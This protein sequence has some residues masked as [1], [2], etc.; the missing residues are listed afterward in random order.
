MGARAFTMIGVGLAGSRKIRA[1]KTDTARWAYVCAHVSKLSRFVGMFELPKAIFAHDVGVCIEDL[2]D[3]IED[4]QRV[5]LIEYDDD[6]EFIRIVAWHRKVN[7]IANASAARSIAIDFVSGLLPDG[8]MRIRAVAEFAVGALE[9]AKQWKPESAD[10]PKLYDELKE[11]LAGDYQDYGE[12][13]LRCLVA[14]TK[15]ASRAIQRELGVVFP[16]YLE[17]R[18]RHR[19]DTVSTQVEV[20]QTETILKRD[21]HET[22]TQTKTKKT[23]SRE[24]SASGGP[25]AGNVMPMLRN[26]DGGPTSEL[27]SSPLASGNGGEADSSGRA[28]R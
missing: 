20:D 2:D 21:E 1:L 22:N 28:R 17:A 5:G 15:T 26:G 19:A 27:L 9:R 18:S 25:Q 10:R 3:I 16:P 23:H 4:L 6:T 24:F 12:E 7:A 11:L 13:L 8:E 14:E